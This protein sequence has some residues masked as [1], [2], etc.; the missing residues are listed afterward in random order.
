MMRNIF[1]LVSRIFPAFC[2]L[3][4]NRF[5]TRLLFKMSKQLYWDSKMSQFQYLTWFWN[6]CLLFI[7][8]QTFSF[9]LNWGSRQISLP[10]SETCAVFCNVCREIHQTWWFTLAD[11]I[12]FSEPRVSVAG[13]VTQNHLALSQKG[14]EEGDTDGRDQYA[15][16]ELPVVTGRLRCCSIC[17]RISENHTLP[18][19][20]PVQS[21][22]IMWLTVWILH[23][24]QLWRTHSFPNWT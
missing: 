11:V 24:V 8:V 22:L 6:Q 18:G 10:I 3:C 12:C 17:E 4:P 7:F 13:Q 20:Q 21:C 9:S 14:D 15:H 16:Q 2:F 23:L 5:E 1:S 19:C